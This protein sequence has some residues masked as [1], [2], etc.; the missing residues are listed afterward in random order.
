MPLP[1]LAG[2]ASLDLELMRIYLGQLSPNQFHNIT[3]LAMVPFAFA[4]VWIVTSKPRG[5]RGTV[6]A[7]A[8]LLMSALAKPNFS[9]AFIPA[10][11]V[12]TFAVFLKAKELRLL[13][14]PLLVIAPTFVYLGVQYLF[15]SQAGIFEDGR[16]ILVVDP[17]V[18][19]NRFTDSIAWST[20]RSLLFPVLVIGFLSALPNRRREI[21]NLAF[22][23][24]VL[25]VAVGQFMLMSEESGLGET[26]FHLNWSWGVIAATKIV[27]V[28]SF[29]AFARAWRFEYG[30][31]FWHKV[32]RAFTLAAF[33]A[34]LASGL[35]YVS[36]ILSGYSYY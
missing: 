19:W 17:L 8:T 15:F 10:Y 29:A 16:S 25:G 14:P 18:Q 13:V 2:L 12:K 22:A 11:M 4:V 28:Y 27:F 6:G 5:L 36:V 32:M 26:I 21:K 9:L 31:R 20:V 33:G 23:W 3:T 1:S 24:L 35:T 30:A 34:H 7:S